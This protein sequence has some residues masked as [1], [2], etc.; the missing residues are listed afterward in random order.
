[1]SWDM[2]ARGAGRSE[3]VQVK[4]YERIDKDSLALIL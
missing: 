2:L 3:I 4:L 1:M